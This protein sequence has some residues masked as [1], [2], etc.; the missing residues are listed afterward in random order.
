MEHEDDA[1]DHQ[2]DSAPVGSDAKRRVDEMRALALSHAVGHHRDQ[3]SN[4][5]TIIATAEAFLKFLV[6]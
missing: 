5:T 3:H 2:T 1:T 6:G 4:D